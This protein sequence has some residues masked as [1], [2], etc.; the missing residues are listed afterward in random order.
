MRAG[1]VLFKA[2]GTEGPSAVD[3]RISLLPGRAV[4]QPR[5]DVK[6]RSSAF[7]LAAG[8][9]RSVYIGVQGSCRILGKHADD[10]VGLALQQ[11]GLAKDALVRAEEVA[12]HAVAENHGLGPMG[13]ILVLRKIAPDDGLKRQHVKVVGGDAAIA[14]VLHVRARPQIYAGGCSRYGGDQCR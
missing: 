5:D 1:V 10:N 11:D 13:T 6:I 8:L 7:A 9:E 2:L 4:A 3:L 12:P 14:H